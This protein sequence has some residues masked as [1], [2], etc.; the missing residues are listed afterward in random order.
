MI[1][2]IRHTKYW[3]NFLILLMMVATFPS[4]AQ[5]GG[6]DNS[7]SPQ[8]GINGWGG[9]AVETIALQTDGKIIIAGEFDAYNLTSR[10]R[11]ARLHTD[12]ALD[13]SFNPGTGANGTIQS[14]LVQHDGKILIAG[15]FTHYN[16]HPAPRLARLLARRCY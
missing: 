14:C 7:F 5:E 13:T 16:G 1:H 11:I 8:P 4:I 6:N 9:S 15:D 3:G 10:P 2:D 12:A